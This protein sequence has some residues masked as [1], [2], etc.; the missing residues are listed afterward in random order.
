MKNKIL[1][2]SLTLLFGVA[3]FFFIITVS[4][5]LPIY[6]RFFYYAHINALNLPKTTGYD[7]QTIKTAFD[8]MMN[9]LTLPNFEF[10]TGALKYSAEGAS[11]FADC[12][13]L[14][15]LN[16]A[17]LIVSSTIIIAVLLLERFKVVSLFRPFKMNV[18]LISA[19]CVLGIFLILAVIIAIDFNNAFIVFHKIFFAGKDNWN[20]YP[21]VDEV[22]TI[23]P[24]QFFLNCAILIILSIILIS[25]G[26]ILFQ[27]IKRHKNNKKQENSQIVLTDNKK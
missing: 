3:V 27:A 14:F 4:I 17:V 19:C 11:H 20:F 15:N 9:Y 22:I 23:L 26:I 25:V 6:L 5:G 1:P 21:E 12:K 8:E 2:F 16:L 13:A 10:S 7:Y 18:S 24:A